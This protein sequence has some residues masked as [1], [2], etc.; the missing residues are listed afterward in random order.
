MLSLRVININSLIIE[1]GISPATISGC[2]CRRVAFFLCRWRKGFRWSTTSRRSTLCQ[3]TWTAGLERA[4]SCRRSPQR[5]SL[6]RSST[7]E[8]MTACCAFLQHGKIQSQQ[9]VKVMLSQGRKL[10]QSFSFQRQRDTLFLLVAFL[11]LACYWP[12]LDGF[13]WHYQ[14]SVHCSNQCRQ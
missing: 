9:N 6:S 14:A 1:A 8:W 13:N 11:V 4:R 2:R 7:W 3:K 5:T 10:H 12:V